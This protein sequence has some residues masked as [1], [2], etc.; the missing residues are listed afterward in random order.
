[1]LEELK[2]QREWKF[3]VL[4]GVQGGG[5]DF[6]DLKDKQE[7]AATGQKINNAETGIDTILNE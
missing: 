2:A 1:M 7:R 3:S 6:K 4:N 5:E